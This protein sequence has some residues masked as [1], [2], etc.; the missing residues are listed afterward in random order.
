MENANTST[1]ICFDIMITLI[2]YCKNHLRNKVE[3]LIREI[4]NL[5]RKNEND[6]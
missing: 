2:T 5:I 3:L 4:N 6:R 1:D